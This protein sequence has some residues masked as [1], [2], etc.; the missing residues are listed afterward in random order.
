MVQRSSHK[1]S[2]TSSHSAARA[3]RSAAGDGSQHGQISLSFDRWNML[4]CLSEV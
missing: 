4:S 2:K 3:S 1:N